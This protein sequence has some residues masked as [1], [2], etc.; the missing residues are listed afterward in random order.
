MSN[1]NDIR[2]QAGKTANKAIKRTGELAENAKKYMKLRVLDAKL[3]AHYEALGRLT[4]K[5]IKNSEQLEEKISESIESIEKLRTE[6]KALNDEIEAD[7]KI[8][9]EEKKEKKEQKELK[10]QEA[11]EEENSDEAAE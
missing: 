8:R 1:W 4:Y 5:Q 10:K 9:A 7:K 6:R 2:K 3:S 11:E